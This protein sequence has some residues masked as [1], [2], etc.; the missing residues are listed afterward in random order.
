[1]HTWSIG[2]G[3]RSLD[4]FLGALAENGI[5]VVADVRSFPG[6][7]LHPHFGKDALATSLTDAGIRYE[8][9][10]GLGGRRRDAA[11]SPHR[12]IRVAAFRAYADHMDSDGFRDDLARLVEL[13]RAAPTAFMCAE[14]L[15]WRCHRR[16]L[17]DRLLVDG[18][19]VTHVLGAGTTEPHRL[20]GVA[21]V[22]ADE[23]IVYDAGTLGL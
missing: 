22:T 1:V 20:W 2:H 6:S 3:A 16:L 19:V 4:E 15:W 18:W 13:A 11:S 21:R 17:S 23:K 10:P 7:R 8:H 14:T 12:A 9:L 5:R